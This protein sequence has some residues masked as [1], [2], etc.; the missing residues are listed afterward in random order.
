MTHSVVLIGPLGPSSAVFDPLIEHFAADLH[1]VLHEH[2]GHGGRPAPTAGF[3]IRDLGDDLLQTLGAVAEHA[4]FI[5]VGLGAMIALSIAVERPAGVRS[6][7]L[8]GVAASAASPVRYLDRARRVAALGLHAVAEEI[9]AGWVTREYLA[10]PDNRAWLLTLL[11]GTDSRCYARCCEALATFD[12]AD[13]LPQIAC[14]T[15]VIAGDRDV[16]VHPKE[17]HRVHELIESS[18]FCS[19]DSTAHVPFIERPIAFSRLVRRQLESL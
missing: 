2:V 3:S 14:P 1:V 5:G 17:S 9:I 18:S 7:A 15:L 13:G 6:L 11:S 4:S 16:G 19:L 12:V 8:A 10:Q